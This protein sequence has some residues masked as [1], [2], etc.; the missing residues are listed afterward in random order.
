MTPVLRGGERRP[1]RNPHTHPAEKVLASM[2]TANRPA[3]GTKLDQVNMSAAIRPACRTCGYWQQ[4]D[5]AEMTEFIR[6]QIRLLG[7]QTSSGTP[8]IE[9]DRHI[10]CCRRFPPPGGDR[11]TNMPTW[12]RTWASDWCGE[13]REIS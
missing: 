2:R 5:T 1:S 3:G 11:E 10:G 6:R 9:K 4:I 7:P 13:W 12:T 8:I